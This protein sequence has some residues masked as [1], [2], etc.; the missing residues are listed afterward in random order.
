MLWRVLGAP[1]GTANTI[2]ARRLMYEIFRRQL[3]ITT[4]VRNIQGEVALPEPGDVP[5]PPLAAD[6]SNLPVY[7]FALKNGGT[8][9]RKR[10]DA[11]RA[12]FD[13]LARQDADVQMRAESG[14]GHILT[15]Y[16]GRSDAMTPLTFS[17]TGVAESLFIATIMASPGRVLL[18]DEP[19]ANLQHGTQVRLLRALSE[20]PN[21]ALVVTHSQLLVPADARITTVARFAMRS[22][23]TRLIRPSASQLQQHLPKITQELRGSSDARALLFAD[24]IVLVEGDSELGGFLA[25]NERVGVLDTADS[26]IQV[27]S[28]D[29]DQ[30]FPTYVFLAEAY[31]VPWTIICDGRAIGEPGRKGLA[32]QL[33]TIGVPHSIAAGDDFPA[34]KSKFA[35]LGVYTLADA[36]AQQIEQHGC[37]APWL[38]AAKQ[39]MDT[40]SKPRLAR[41]IAERHD[42]PHA[43]EILKTIAARFGQP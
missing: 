8:E 7:L 38:Q 40:T 15:I 13:R 4:N 41:W 39:A 2:D 31:E 3:I 5:I 19:G 25:W 23:T 20:S 26:D 14:R 43:V 27:F 36:A 34:R 17:G 9:E 6:G 1:T 10:F 29:G 12:Q 28:V 33:Q 22:G 42:C 24:G 35:Q 21:Q 37:I 30:E 16:V 32:T 18:L 11:I